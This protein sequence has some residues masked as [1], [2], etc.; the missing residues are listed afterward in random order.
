[1]YNREFDKS[2]FAISSMCAHGNSPATA[3]RSYNFHYRFEKKSAETSKIDSD[4]NIFIYAPSWNVTGGIFSLNGFH[5][6]SFE[7]RK[8][9]LRNLSSKWNQRN[10]TLVRKRYEQWRQKYFKPLFFPSAF[11]A[12]LQWTQIFWS[13]M[14]AFQNVPVSEVSTL[15]PKSFAVHFFWMD[16]YAEKLSSWTS[17]IWRPWR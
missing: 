11:I 3:R 5:L 17:T 2:S 6:K 13:S 16:F 4:D 1:M 9:H 14:L 10:K 8:L 12:F 7:F 15:Y